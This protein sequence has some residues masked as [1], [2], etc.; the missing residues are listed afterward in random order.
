MKIGLLI[1]IVSILL[2]VV[3]SLIFVTENHERKTASKSTFGKRL[4][5][6]EPSNRERV[7]NP[8]E[9][10]T[11]ERAL[12]FFFVCGGV[13]L[14]LMTLFTKVPMF[15]KLILLAIFA[16]IT[17]LAY[18]NLNRINKL[19]KN[20]DAVYKQGKPVTATVVST[21]KKRVFYSSFP[22]YGVTV[23][24]NDDAQKNVTFY[25]PSKMLHNS[26]PV[27]SIVNGTEL[28]GEYFFGQMVGIN[29]AFAD[30]KGEITTNR[31]ND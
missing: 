25:F 10:K 7:V 23:K 20:R 6:I 28:N 2:F 31:N 19:C 16:G 12:S 21:T 24:T 27:G 11:L 26:C 1:I 22:A 8:F 13:L 5:Q 15:G 29:L 30:E 14:L 4:L 18:L 17:S 9:G 3:G